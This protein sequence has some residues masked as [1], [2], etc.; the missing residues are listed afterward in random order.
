[1]K[2]F[3]YLITAVTI[4]AFVSA[5]YA[6]PKKKVAIAAKATFSIGV[7][8]NDVGSGESFVFSLGAGKQI[9]VTQGNLLTKFSAMFTNGQSFTLSQ[10]SGPRT[11]QLSPNAGT[12]SNANVEIQADCGLPPGRSYLDGIFRAPPG[13]TIVLQKDGKDDLTLTAK[14]DSSATFS[15]NPFKFPTPYLD[16]TPYTLSIKSSTAGQICSVD[17]GIRGTI[18]LSPGF[19]RVG[20]DFTYELLSRNSDNSKF[21]TYYE[22]NSPVV[23]GDYYDE[24]RY[25]AF[26]SSGVGLGG[27]LGKKRQIIWRDRNTGETRMISIGMNGVEGN[28][29][30]FAP[31]ISTDGMSVA[32]ESYATNLVPIDTNGVRDIFVWNATTNTVTAVS[33]GAGESETNS[34]SFEPVISRDGSLVAFSSSASNLSPGVSGTSTVNVYL[35]KVGS[36]QAPILISV[37][38]K[39]KKGVGGSNPSISD[40]GIRIAFYSYASTLVENDKNGMWDIFLYDSGKPKLKRLSLTAE[41]SERNQGT[42][43]ISRVVAPTISAN[44]SWVVFSSTAS[45]IVGGDNN[46]MQDVF[47]ANVATGQVQRISTAADGTEGNGD[48]PIGQGEKVAISFDGTWVA[49]STAAKNLGGDIILKNTTGGETRV[50]TSEQSYGVGRPAISRVGGYV[51]FGAGSKLDSKYPSSGIFARFTGISRCRFCNR[52]SAP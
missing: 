9:S 47:I 28:G 7:T 32:F 43:S 19:I 12:I 33:T 36:G 34:E 46:K 14:P 8:V 45:N 17:K 23:G 38:P 10:L 42:E 11:C 44:G 22:S 37:D 15:S 27:S 49:F 18:G 2:L 24:G 29:D 20:C 31:S 21:G 4:S 13:T 6:Q 35:K 41:G 26:V 51:V 1:M 39:T 48:S 30:S 25:V 5:A 52:E 16:G 3:K 40:D 50:V